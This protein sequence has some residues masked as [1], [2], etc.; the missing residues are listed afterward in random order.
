MLWDISFLEWIFD[1]YILLLQFIIIILLPLLFISFLLQIIV[2][3]IRKVKRIN[4]IVIS[5]Y[6][7]NVISNHAQQ[8]NE[9]VKT[10]ISAILNTS[11]NVG[12]RYWR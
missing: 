3:K 1:N 5:E 11:Y 10:R 4:G 2:D 8:L 12:D 7:Y 6:N 9:S